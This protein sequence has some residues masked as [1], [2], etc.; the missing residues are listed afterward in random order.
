MRQKPGADTADLGEHERSELQAKAAELSK[1]RNFES[2][3]G[4]QI[5]AAAAAVR[6]RGVTCRST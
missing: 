1:L 2:Q 3:L 5:D 6:T 4:E